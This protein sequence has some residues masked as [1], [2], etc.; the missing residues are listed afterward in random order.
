LLS[1]AGWSDTRVLGA[2]SMAEDAEDATV[3]ISFSPAPA[4]SLADAS[5]RSRAFAPALALVAMCFP[6][7]THL[8]F[9]SAWWGLLF[10]WLLALYCAALSARED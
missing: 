4:E 1:E 10:W 9:Y 3:L 7:N 2:G 8:A 5:A 6:L